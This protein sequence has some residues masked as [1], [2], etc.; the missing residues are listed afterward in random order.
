MSKESIPEFSRPQ[1]AA[2]TLSKQFIV[3][4]LVQK[5][6][7]EFDSLASPSQIVYSRSFV[8]SRALRRNVDLSDLLEFLA[9]VLHS[10]VDRLIDAITVFRGVLAN[11]LRNA[12]RA[13]LRSAHRAKVR[14]LA[15]VTRNRLVVHGA[16]RNRIK[17]KIKLV[18]P[19]KFE[20]RLRQRVVP[21][22]RVRVAFAKVRSVRC[23]F[24]RNHA[25][26]DV[27]AIRQP[28][29]FLGSDVAQQR[30]A[31]VPNVGSADRACD[32]VVSR[33]DIRDERPECV[34]RSF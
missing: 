23:D 12:H 24:V 18:V 4:K 26:F 3:A 19:P 13:K 30:T 31:L 17:R 5:S 22:L 29:V 11:V 28:Q 8:G 9:L 27:V 2:R 32:V 7:H 21:L 33:C 14:D 34:K 6:A 15:G 20:A 1:L 16:R 10:N 25:C